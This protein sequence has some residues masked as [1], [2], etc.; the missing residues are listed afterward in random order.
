MKDSLDKQDKTKTVDIFQ[1]LADSIQ[2]EF[3]QSIFINIIP[4]ISRK[5]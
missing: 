1:V 5:F 4:K 2:K 3:V